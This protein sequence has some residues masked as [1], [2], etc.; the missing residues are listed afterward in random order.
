VILFLPFFR[1]TTAATG[2]LR[3]A[4]DGGSHAIFKFVIFPPFGITHDFETS[5]LGVFLHSTMSIV[6]VAFVFLVSL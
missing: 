4:H 1:V 3:D 5:L 2:G 6:E